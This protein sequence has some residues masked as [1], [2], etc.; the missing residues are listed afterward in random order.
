MIETTTISPQV[1]EE[2]SLDYA[3]LRKEGL[4]HITRLAGRVWTD[5]N[6]HDPGI[7]ILE[8]L[9]YAI[10][11][12]SHRTRLDIPDILAN[13]GSGG[14][15]PKNF[16]PA[17]DIMHVRATTFDDYRRIM[18]DAPYVKNAWIEEAKPEVVFYAN[19]TASKLVT[20][21]RPVSHQFSEA[22]NINGLYRILLEFDEHEVHGDLNSSTFT[23]EVIEVA[24]TNPAPL[25]RLAGL[26]IRARIQFPFW[27]KPGAWNMQWLRRNIVRID[28]DVL[29]QPQGFLVCAE[30]DASR[31]KFGFKV[32]DR[33]TSADVTSTY[34]AGL[35]NLVLDQAGL[36]GSALTS[37]AKSHIERSLFVQSQLGKLLDKVMANRNLCEDFLGFRSLRIEDIGL[38]ADVDLEPDAN[39]DA[40]LAKMYY[41]IGKFLSPEVNFY[42]IE[43]LLDK[44]KR[45]EEIFEGPSL[46]HGFMDQD[47]LDK[48]KRMKSLHVSDLI[49]IIMD[50]PG[51]R[52][53][54]NVQIAGFPQGALNPTIR[55]VRWCLKLAFEQG[56]VPRLS[57]DRSKILFFKDEIPYMPDAT[58]VQTLLDGMRA[59]DRLRQQQAQANISTDLPIPE[60]T[61]YSLDTYHSL[62]RDF[63]LTYR[64]GEEELP[65]SA[66]DLRKG[67]A[68]QLKGYLT[69]FEQ[70]LASYLS[71]LS[72]TAHLFDMTDVAQRT[73]YNQV[74][75]DIPDFDLLNSFANE[76]L[77]LDEINGASETQADFLK[78]R[79]RFLDHLLG[80]FAEQFTDYAMLVYA[81]GSPRPDLDLKNDK[82][83]F[84]QEYPELSANRG[85]AFNY[86]QTPVWNTN[87]VS[88]LEH[89]LARLLGMQDYNRR[90]L[91]NNSEEGFHLVEHVLLRPHGN[92]PAPTR[93]PTRSHQFIFLPIDTTPTCGCP[94]VEDPYT[95]RATLVLPAWSGRFAD[96][97]FRRFFERTARQETPSHVLLKMCW[98]DKEQMAK[99]EKIYR[100]WLTALKN[101][102]VTDT[103]SSPAWRAPLDEAARDL[104]E[105]M[106]K[107]KSIYPTA[108]LHDCFDNGG[109]APIRL[110]TTALGNL[111]AE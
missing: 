44:G 11:D 33:E 1:P 25:R 107:L 93:P 13:D 67:Q 3:F 58:N 7:T 98:I 88:G 94:S 72:N 4:R 12:L 35:R 49:Q 17:E 45:M 110:G 20:R 6:V 37:P 59:A 91:A 10:T 57:A 78:R 39:V 64:L 15:Y 81:G 100:S 27:D 83:R 69:F 42:S 105:I 62:Q 95:F 73:Y 14:P 47:E 111:E 29:R 63:P 36:R 79:N 80:R 46:A 106:T 54:K 89:R 19:K 96:Q 23:T 24:A 86:R 32:T 21:K 5:H 66:T 104:I 43:Q 40:T 92:P 56:F 26:K 60:G 90:R 101:K 68:K 99:F 41:E 2:K 53:V 76:G 87:N 109:D 8:Y 102:D 74:P 30:N 38:C 108:T 84:L 75:G 55:S 85:G 61:Y 51:I 22:I 34:I 18:M 31:F 77:L 97:S 82:I 70:L 71:Q 9:S 103:H 28:V 16:Y 52:A 65:D 50:I 48:A